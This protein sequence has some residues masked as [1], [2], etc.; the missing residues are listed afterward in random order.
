VTT[1]SLTLS[2]W[3]GFR[4]P[5]PLAPWIETGPARLT[6]TDTRFADTA[7]LRLTRMGIELVHDGLDQGPAVWSLVVHGP[8]LRAQRQIEGN[9]S[10]VP[11]ALSEAVAGAARGAP[12]DIV[13]HLRA[14]RRTS[15]LRDPGGRPLGTITDIE[16]T[17]LH[18]RRVALRSREL[19]VDALAEAPSSLVATVATALQA[20]GAAPADPTPSLVRAL[21]PRAL[22]PPDPA[23]SAPTEPPTVRDV[24]QRALA[25]SVRRLLRHDPIVRLDADDE[26][27]HQMRVSTRRLRSDLRTFG[28][29]L[30]GSDLVPIVDELRWLAATLGEVRDLDV[31]AA[32]LETASLQMPDGDRDGGAA[33]VARLRSGRDRARQTLLHA[34]S[35]DRYLSLVNRL[36]ELTLA[37]PVIDVDDGERPIEDVLVD[38]VRAPWSKLRKQVRTLDDDTSD[39]ALHEARIRAKRTRYAAEA[40]AAFVPPAEKHAERIAAL[41]DVLGDH[42][43]AVVAET[44]LREAA[45]KE[46]LAPVEAFAAGWLAADRRARADALRDQW[47]PRWTRARKA[48]AWLDR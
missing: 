6:T 32:K 38:L 31:L 16:I 42:Q 25:T 45:V 29:V 46:E 13:A 21:G 44:W 24:V 41:Q 33:L 8:G 40:V 35:S 3:P 9:A 37:P 30:D 20:A 4:L 23:I 5:A 19:E 34:L 27:V 14:H 48:A 47:G 12:V 11:A 22:A 17:V 18:G 28:P 7:D 26:G 10:T 2:A 1:R 15:E 36:V 39:D 43:D